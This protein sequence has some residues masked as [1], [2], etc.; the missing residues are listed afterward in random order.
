MKVSKLTW[1]KLL[2]GADLTHAEYRVLCN[3]ATY[4][5]EYGRHAHPSVARLMADCR[6][7][8][9][10]VKRTL[11][12]LEA[13]GALTLTKRGGGTRANVYAIDL[14][15]APRGAT[16]DPLSGSVT[17]T[18]P[19]A[20]QGVGGSPVTQRGATHDPLSDSFDQ[21]L[22][23]SV[24]S[25][26]GGPRELPDNW[27]PNETHRRMAVR[28][29]L[30]IDEALEAFMATTASYEKRTDWDKTFGAF[31]TDFSVDQACHWGIA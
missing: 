5:N 10:T 15:T 11:R 25:S 17:S 13:K 27:T 19:D 18:G 24:T 23:P 7:S 20:P 16:H 29:G 6:M 3:V 31:L 14:G 26:A 8:K 12:S 9:S 22:K 30:E 4:T 28:H 21:V 1:P 2:R